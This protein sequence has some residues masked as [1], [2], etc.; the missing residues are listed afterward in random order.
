V[1]FLVIIEL[2]LCALMMYNTVIYFLKSTT[3]ISSEVNFIPLNNINYTVNVEKSIFSM[4]LC[5]LDSLGEVQNMESSF[6]TYATIE[7]VQYE[8]HGNEPYEQFNTTLQPMMD[9]LKYFNDDG[10]S[11]T[12]D[13]G[14]CYAIPLGSNVS[15]QGSPTSQDERYF[16]IRVKQ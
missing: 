11:L 15:I 10:T 13:Y 4:A 9:P 12:R 14:N 6:N 1:G 8:R 16:S 5:F 7:L 2:F 3:R